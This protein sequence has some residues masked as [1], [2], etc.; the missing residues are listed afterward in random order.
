VGVGGFE[1]GWGGGGGGGGVG[2][3]GFRPS[4]GPI[5]FGSTFGSPRLLN[6]Y[7]FLYFFSKVVKKKTFPFF[8]D[9]RLFSIPRNPLPKLNHLVDI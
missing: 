8:V 5:Y 7:R 4:G 1:G 9:R 2:G 6:F 3:R